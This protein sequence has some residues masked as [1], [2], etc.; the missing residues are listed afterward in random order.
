MEGRREHVYF[1]G[2][3]VSRSRDPYAFLTADI[4]APMSITRV[5]DI[6]ELPHEYGPWTAVS[7]NFPKFDN[8]QKA[9]QY[10][11]A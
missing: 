2:P 11:P 9:G 7:L 10:L 4:N 1:Y 3:V 8:I 6:S 5:S